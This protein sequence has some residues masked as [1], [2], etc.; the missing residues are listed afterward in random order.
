RDAFRQPGLE[1]R[2]GRV[3]GRAV[4]P[5]LGEVGRPEVDVRRVELV[6]LG[7]QLVEE[8]DSRATI[9]R[10]PRGLAAGK[11]VDEGAI[12]GERQLGRRA[13]RRASGGAQGH[14]SDPSISIFT[15]RLNSIAYSMGSSFVKTSRKPWTIR[16][17]ASFSVRPRLIR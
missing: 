8:R 4:R 5:D 10:E 12:R 13:P 6:R 16:F 9:V 7:R 14:P 3:V 2:P 1:L 11:G 17:V 15:S